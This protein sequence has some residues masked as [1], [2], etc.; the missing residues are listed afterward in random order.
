MQVLTCLP[1]LYTRQAEMSPDNA[2]Q[3]QSARRQD[4]HPGF[5]QGGKNRSGYQADSALDDCPP[6]VLLLRIRR[7]QVP[8]QKLPDG[9]VAV[10]LIVA[11]AEPVPLI[12]IDVVV[13]MDVVAA[14]GG[15]HFI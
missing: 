6:T 2:W 5:C 11:I 14:H 4:L 15:H 1:F 3:R 9:P 8:V 13:N 7:L 12:G 10:D